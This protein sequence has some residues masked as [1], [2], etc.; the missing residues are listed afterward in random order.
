[1]HRPMHHITARKPILMLAATAS[2]AAIGQTTQKLD[3]C[4]QMHELNEVALVEF[5]KY[6]SDI[7]ADTS[8]F[9]ALVC[10]CNYVDRWTNGAIRETGLFKA[11]EKEGPWIEYGDSLRVMRIT[12]YIGGKR[13]GECIS[14]YGNGQLAIRCIY[15]DDQYDGEYAEYDFEGNLV[16]KVV[17]EMGRIVSQSVEKEWKP[18]GVVEYVWPIMITALGVDIPPG[19]Y[20]WENGKRVFLR[21]LGP[22]ELETSITDDDLTKS[23]LTEYREG[24]R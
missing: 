5:M 1:M 24:K 11:C 15:R 18:D 12:N 19:V 20:V 17:Y 16:K 10:N 6:R 2:I 23:K 8:T 7:A 13:N 4:K 3:T 22:Q 9:Y 14:Y 21:A